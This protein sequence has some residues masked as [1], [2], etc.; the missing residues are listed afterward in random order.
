MQ[1]NTLLFSVNN[2]FQQQHSKVIKP[3]KRLKYTIKSTA[4]ETLLFTYRLLYLQYS[5]RWYIGNTIQ[6]STAMALIIKESS[7]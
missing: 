1:F 5:V 2:L 6:H 3:A 4:K 7:L